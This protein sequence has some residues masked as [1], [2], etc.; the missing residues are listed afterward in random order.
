MSVLV[1]EGDL[2]PAQ[3]DH[4][5]WCAIN[6]SNGLLYS[7]NSE[8]NYSLALYQHKIKGSKLILSYVRRL[9]LHS[10][11]GTHGR[12]DAVQG[13]VFSNDGKRL[14]ISS[15]SGYGGGIFVFN[16]QTGWRIGHIKVNYKAWAGEE[17]EGLTIWDL[18]HIMLPDSRGQRQPIAIPGIQ[19][20]I[21]LIMIDNLGKGDDD[22]FF[23]HFR[24][25]AEKR[26]IAP[27]DL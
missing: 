4:A 22:L 19:G 6:P 5:A 2:D 1:A 14:Y 9:T 15:D 3:Q 27:R 17:L 20:Q 25:P 18:D 26:G 21:H 13:G 16:P 11:C 7:S 12:I 23:K 24:V 10:E 8:K